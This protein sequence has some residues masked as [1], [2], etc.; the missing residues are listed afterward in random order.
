MSF[1]ESTLVSGW[2]STSE[3]LECWEQWVLPVRLAP[4]TTTPDDQSMAM[5]AL[6]S[7]LTRIMFSIVAIVNANQ[8]KIPHN[9]ELGQKSGIVYPFEIHV[10]S[11]KSWGLDSLLFWKHDT[12]GSPVPQYTSAR[13]PISSANLVRE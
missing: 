11:E 13:A 3:T 9:V 8:R 1:F 5:D 10:P 4:P 12:S 2:I 7:T 6:R